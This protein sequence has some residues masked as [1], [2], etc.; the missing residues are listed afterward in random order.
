MARRSVSPSPRRFNDMK[1]KQHSLDSNNCAIAEATATP[2]TAVSPSSFLTATT[3]QTENPFI[4]QNDSKIEL[5]NGGEVQLSSNKYENISDN[6]SEISDEGYRSLGLIQ[7]NA[8]KRI[9]LHSQA[10]NEDAEIN[11]KYLCV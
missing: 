11:G 10:S 7:T 6:G 2:T 5:N 3:N 8:Q 4:I 9:S 1:K